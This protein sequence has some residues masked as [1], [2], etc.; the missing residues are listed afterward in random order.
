MTLPPL[1]FA[2]LMWF[3]G[4]AAVVWLCSRPRATFGWSLALAGLV[5]LGAGG[6]VW[7]TAGDTSVGGAYTA[8]TA[9]IA[10]WGWHE[11]SFL[12]GHVAGPNRAE[13]PAGATGWARFRA[14]TATV[15]HHE[16]AIAATLLV[17]IAMT[18]GQP[19]GVA[20][21]TFGLLFA[22]RLSAKFNLYLGVPN[23]SDEVFPAHLAH[24][25]SYFRTAPMNWL[26]PLSILGGAATAVLAWRAAELS[27]GGTAAGMALLAGLAVLG[28]TEHL[29]LVL[30]L[31]DG[32]L[33]AWAL[34]G[35]K[36]VRAAGIDYDG[37]RR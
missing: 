33:F 11:M 23:L 36:A 20:P 4:T 2:L 13:C 37:R 3:I 27:T 31:R 35:N 30:P 34:H 15:I 26:F 12:M 19:N 1:L 32:R 10:I 5:A 25:K 24:L 21:L 7:A 14:A 6:A 18:W 8:F 29:F 9:A 17:L 22:M 28:V 16:L